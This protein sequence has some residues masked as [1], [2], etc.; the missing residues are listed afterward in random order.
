MRGGADLYVIQAHTTGAF[1]VGRSSDVATR[2]RQLQTGCPYTL[3]ILLVLKNQGHREREMHQRLRGYE[4]QQEVGGEWFIE[5]GLPSLG[6]E[7]YE[8]L[9]PCAIEAWW[10]TSS[11][12]VHPPGPPRGWVADRDALL[13]P[14]GSTR[15]TGP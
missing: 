9:D 14:K 1:K 10:R 8:L 11:G 6:D 2:L 7:V 13:R 3:R 4:S 15:E 5:P 12:V